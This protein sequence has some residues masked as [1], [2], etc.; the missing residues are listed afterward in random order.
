MECWICVMCTGTTVTMRMCVRMHCLSRRPDRR[1]LMAC[2]DGTPPPHPFNASPSTM[3]LR[4]FDLKRGVRV[5]D[6]SRFEFAQ[7]LDMQPYASEDVPRA[8]AGSC[9]AVRACACLFIAQCII[10]LDSACGF[11]VACS[12]LLRCP[13][14]HGIIQ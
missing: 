3:P 13:I 4:R 11:A 10:F 9:L 5:K 7:Q 1:P 2:M 12:H 8:E 6:N 14:T